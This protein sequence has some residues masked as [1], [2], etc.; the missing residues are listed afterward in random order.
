MQDKKI[1]WLWV[2]VIAAT[3]LNPIAS[4]RLK[5]E[6]WGIVDAVAAV[7]FLPSIAIMDIRKPRP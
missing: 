7:L 6:T 1:G 4:L 5:R 3:V 2:F